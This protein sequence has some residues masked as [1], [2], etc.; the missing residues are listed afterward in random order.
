M[1]KRP[2]LSRTTWRGPLQF[3]IQDYNILDFSDPTRFSEM[4]DRLILGLK[5][6]YGP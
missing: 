6:Y 2:R 3:Q 4:A 5:S 1:A